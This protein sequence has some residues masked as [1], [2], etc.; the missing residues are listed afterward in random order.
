MYPDIKYIKVLKGN[1]SALHLYKK[2]GFTIK[3]LEEGKMPGNKS[4][5]VQAYVLERGTSAN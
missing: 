3:Y 2:L 5:S 4:F 1:F